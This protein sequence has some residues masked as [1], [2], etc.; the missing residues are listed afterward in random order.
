MIHAL[1]AVN[2]VVSISLGLFP[3][4]IFTTDDVLKMTRM[5]VRTE[6]RIRKK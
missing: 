2:S 5:A 3:L 6:E 1:L 4:I